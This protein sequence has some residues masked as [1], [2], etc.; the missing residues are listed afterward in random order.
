MNVWYD[1]AGSTETMNFDYLLHLMKLGVNLTSGAGGHLVFLTKPGRGNL[2]L[3]SSA[4]I[5]PNTN[6]KSNKEG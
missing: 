1:I 4:S 3:V 2:K 6:C 5:P